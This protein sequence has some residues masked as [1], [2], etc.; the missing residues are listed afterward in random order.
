MNRNNKRSYFYFGHNIQQLSD[1]ECF[2][3]Y[4]SFNTAESKERRLN[5]FRQI[6]SQMAG[7]QIETVD[8]YIVSM[9]EY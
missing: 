9:N 5:Y 7:K 6:D 3:H 4:F 1:A 2:L 8:I